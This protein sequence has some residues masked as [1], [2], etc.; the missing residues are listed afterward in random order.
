MSIRLLHLADLHLGYRPGRLGDRAGDRRAEFTVA[1]RRAIEFALDEEQFIDAV[2]VVG[3]LFERH[4]PEQSDV[5]LV[6]SQFQR[7]DEA[8]KPIILVPGTHD[9]LQYPN[10]VYRE[11]SFP[12]MELIDTP[13]VGQPLTFTLN[14]EQAHFY[15]LAYQPGRS[16][17]PLDV[18]QAADVTGRHVTLIHGSL[19]HNPEW[20][21]HTRDIPLHLES[22]LESGMDYIALGHYHSFQEYGNG[23]PAVVYCGGLERKNVKEKSERMLVVA[24]LGD[25]GT[26]VEKTPYPARLVVNDSLDIS[27]LEEYSPET[28]AQEVRRRAPEGAIL[29]LRLEGSAEE[30]IDTESLRKQLMPSYLF[31]LHIDDQTLLWHSGRLEQWASEPTVRGR[32]TRRMMEKI[33]QAPPEDVSTLNLALKLALVEF[34]RDDQENTI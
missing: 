11:E 4:R 33:R 34:M 6:R 32:F 10:C 8:G 23:Q 18:F 20:E 16:K 31:H 24:E 19:M 2:M 29:D 26:R 5:E 22:L 17:T 30:P 9:G 14:G 15:G 12:G 1:F 7:L 13:N 28:L 27:P 25:D 21:A 3:D